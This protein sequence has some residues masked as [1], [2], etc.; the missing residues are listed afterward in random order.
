[1]QNLSCKK[2]PGKD[3]TGQDLKDNTPALAK[4]MGLDATCTRK[5]NN[6]FTTGAMSAGMSIPFVDLK[7]QASFTNANN[8]MAESGC[9]QFFVNASTAITNNV[10]MQCTLEQNSSTQNISEHVSLK[11]N[12]DNREKDSSARTKKYE[13]A[14]KA[15]EDLNKTAIQA[16]M[17][18]GKDI[19]P[20]VQ[21]LIENA[22]KLASDL[23]D[24]PTITIEGSTIANVSSSSIKILNQVTSSMVTALQS[25]YEQAVTAS[26]NNHLESTL[27]QGAVTNNVK[28]VVQ[29]KIQNNTE[30]YNKSIKS[31]LENT[32]VSVNK[33][34]TINISS[35]GNI[36][37]KDVNINNTFMTSLAAENLIQSATQAGT[38][39]ATN[40]INDAHNTDITKASSPGMADLAKALDKVNTDAIKAGT[41][42]TSVVAYIVLAIIVLMVIGGGMYAVRNSDKIAKAV[43]TAKTPKI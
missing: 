17:M 27:G 2:N 10:N 39:I 30:N 16:A 12:I 42:S 35:S 43:Q 8:S 41:G 19:P 40:L 33:D 6:A 9:G 29:D 1:M 21:T 26:V 37:L 3:L 23:K 18:S 5:A 20:S 11:I 25:N 36:V 13:E 4:A 14:L 34:G 24:P 32:N 22:N 38:I 28:K 31:N 7:G 15:S